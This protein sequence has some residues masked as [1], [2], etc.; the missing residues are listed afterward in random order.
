M[1][2]VEP[3]QVVDEMKENERERAQRQQVRRRQEHHDVCRLSCITTIFAN[4]PPL[5][6]NTV[7]NIRDGSAGM[8]DKVSIAFGVS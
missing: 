8:K 5:L 6:H 4:K 7:G 2:F 1:L 3:Q